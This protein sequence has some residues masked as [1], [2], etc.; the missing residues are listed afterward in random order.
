MEFN[1]LNFSLTM[2]IIII[3]AG[4]SLAGFSS[5][6]VIDDLIFYPPAVSER[7]QWYRFITCGFIHAD[8]GHL[9]FNMISLYML[10]TPV[11]KIFMKAQLFGENGKLLYLALYFSALVVSLLPT[12]TKN[13]NNSYYRSLGASGA[14][15]AVVFT[16]IMLAPMTDLYLF[17]IPIP[18][19]AFI[20]GFL[21]LGISAYL[22]RRGGGRI[23]HSAHFWGSVYGAVF[24]IVTS[25]F[26]AKYPVVQNFADSVKYW[27]SSKFGG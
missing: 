20:F 4:L 15:A 1:T 24:I 10:G 27:I 16:Y 7:N 8:L 13:K 18:V 26:I 9:A 22:D 12:Y 3:T 19:P 23:N 14:V 17:F 5:R 25:Y 11:E 21:Y 2:I 6:K